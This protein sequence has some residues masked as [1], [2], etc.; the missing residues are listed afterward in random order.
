MDMPKG[1]RIKHGWI[2]YR[3]Q[4]EGK[5]IAHATGLAPNATNLKAAARM[6][7]AHIQRLKYQEQNAPVDP[8]NFE[9]VAQEYLDK[10]KW[11]LSTR[12]SYRDA[13]NIHWSALAG[14]DIS[15]ITANELILHDE[16]YP[17]PSVKTRNNALVPLRGVFK[18]A[19]RKGLIFGGNPAAGLTQQKRNKDEPDPYTREDRDKLLEALEG[20]H[21]ELFFNLAFGTGMRT[22]ELLAVTWADFD[23]NKLHVNKSIVRGQVKGTKTGNNRTVILLPNLADKLRSLPRPI[24]GGEIITNQYGRRYQSGYHLNK[25]FTAAHE[26]TGVRRSRNTNYP[27]RH[28]YASLALSAGVKPSL[29]AAQLG[30]NVNVLL[31]VYAKYL[32]REDD[33]AELAKM[34]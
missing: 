6:R 24:H 26:A 12:N 9:S 8:Q 23:G 21:G 22:G 29:V 32:P 20:T 31:A 10:G 27:W 18:Q 3:F 2:E 19:I 28:T 4:F 5:T 13:L 15:T 33:A 25:H 16:A 11:A 17:W 14:R 34:M 7:A 30:H 1:V